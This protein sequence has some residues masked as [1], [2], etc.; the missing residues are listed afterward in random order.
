MED[1]KNNLTD[2]PY[3]VLFNILLNINLKD[4]ANYCQTSKRASEI[5]RD[6]SFWR[7]KL[8]GDYGKQGL[9]EGITWKQQY[10]SKEIKVINSTIAAGNVYYGIVDDQGNLYVSGLRSTVGS[11]YN[12]ESPVKVEMKSKVVSVIAGHGD[13]YS[14]PFIGAVTA[15]GEVYIWGGEGPILSPPMK[16]HK[17]NFPRHGKIVKI[18]RENTTGRY[19]I[20]MDSG[21]AYLYSPAMLNPILIQPSNGRKIVDLII[22]A[23][24]LNRVLA[25]CYFLNDH[26]DVYFFYIV[27][28]EGAKRIKLNFPYPIRQLSVSNDVNAALSIKGEV[29]IW[30]PT[31]WANNDK[32]INYGLYGTKERPVFKF[33]VRE[34]WGDI[35]PN[36]IYKANLPTFINSISAGYGNLAAVTNAGTVYVWG[37]NTGNRLVDEIEEMKL[38]YSGK[39]FIL[40]GYNTPEIPFPLELKLESKIRS[41]SLG[42]KFTIAL[43]NDGVINYWGI[44]EAGPEDKT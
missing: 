1:P 33:K 24:A 4:L 11:I 40:S 28:V 3:E 7:V 21:L 31:N 19:G 38:L 14:Y 2:F 6:Q 22:P 30:G 12:S 37:S 44:P 32:T 5:C 20:I 29:Y 41:I 26:G 25:M 15:D 17:M 23:Q 9:I 42:N 13:N 36:E 34:K 16:P 10:Q 27:K 43:T 35:I 39:M 18:D 8:W